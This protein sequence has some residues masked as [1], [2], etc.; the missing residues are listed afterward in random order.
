M[1]GQQPTDDLPCRFDDA[2]RKENA[3]SCPSATLGE[4]S[5]I[6][7]PSFLDPDLSKFIKCRTCVDG[8][9]TPSSRTHSCKS[10]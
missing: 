1:K 4:T 10:P 8:P 3:A 2:K 9:L 5:D 7:E 6:P